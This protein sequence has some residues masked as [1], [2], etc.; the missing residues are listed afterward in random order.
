[1]TID[2]LKQD[3]NFFPWEIPA[4]VMKWATEHFSTT[5][6]Y[7]SYIH[8]IGETLVVRTFAYRTRK[9]NNY[10]LEITEVERKTPELEWAVRKNIFFTSLGGYHPVYERKAC[11]KST[12]YGYY[13]HQFEA[14]DF[15]KWMSEKPMGLFTKLINPERVCELDK[16]KYCGYSG[17]QDLCDYLRLYEKNPQVELFGK[18][19]VRVC[20]SYISKCKKDR[21]FCRFIKDNVDEINANGSSAV[22]Y[23]Y[24]HNMT[25]KEASKFLERKRAAERATRGFYRIR[26]SGVDRIKIHEYI[27]E[28]KIYAPLYADY[29]RAISIL[30]YDLTDTKNIYPKE[31]MRMHDLRIN[32]YSSLKAKED[33]KKRRA[34]DKKI[35]AAAELYQPYTLTTEDYTIILPQRTKDFVDEGRKLHH[36]VGQM[37]Y[38]KKMANG[39]CLIAFIRKTG[40]VGKPYVTVEYLLKEKRVS[41]IYGDHDSKP[42]DEVIEFVNRWAEALTEGLRQQ[43]RRTKC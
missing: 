36:C 16:Y 26:E 24:D 25:I 31:F 28:N 15:D 30:G 21:G 5:N 4:E 2:E 32:E 34:F 41:Q 38:D 19:G 40:E 12:Y 10:N 3:A 11:G 18:L 17:N 7:C 22:I 8:I 37:G 14:E 35:E 6:T 20:K 33:A 9:S 1:M 42:A 29:F 23:A 39:V 13:Y 27:C 43:N